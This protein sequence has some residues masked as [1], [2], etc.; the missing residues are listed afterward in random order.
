MSLA[1]ERVLTYSNKSLVDRRRFA[2]DRYANERVERRCGRPKRI[3]EL[4]TGV[5]QTPG[6]GKGD[7]DQ[8]MSIRAA[9]PI[10]LIPPSVLWSAIIVAALMPVLA[11]VPPVLRAD[12]ILPRSAIWT[13]WPFTPG[14]TL[15]LL[16]SAWLYISGQRNATAPLARRAG[17]RHHL[18]YFGGLAAI[19]LA[20]QSPIDPLADHLF[21][22]HQVEHMLLRTGGPM[23]LMLAAP[24]A[25]LTRG[26]PSWV[27]RRVLPPLLGNPFVRALGVLGQPAITTV[28]F[29]GVTYFWMIPRYHDLAVVDEPIHYLW[30]TTL[31]ISGLIFF[32]R[33]LDQR[34]YPL[35]ASLGVRL[36]MF[37]FASM[38]NILLGSYLSFKHGVLYHA[39]DAMGRYWLSPAVDEQ[40]GG[41]TMWIP[42]SMMFAATSM[43]MIYRWARQ[44]ERTAARQR[45][46]G[47]APPTAEE[48]VASRRSANRK[49]AIGLL[50][51]AA[52]VLI[53]SLSVALT[54]RYVGGPP[55]TSGF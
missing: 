16:A 12:H 26:L 52:S 32:W 2:G 30:H 36:C 9:R 7:P 47:A 24:Q 22:A 18:A 31:L 19:F 45:G 4:R 53:I 11:A 38:G 3:T 40:F 43:L 25:A 42:G 50:A 34:P 14:I 8:R 17:V 13:D 54:D 21:V 51:F 5:D 41:L 44:E 29:V 28:L 35:N 39:Y 27:R 23:L 1:A 33:L 55:G 46:I 49:M 37:W 6:L 48:F 20:L 10:R 15:S